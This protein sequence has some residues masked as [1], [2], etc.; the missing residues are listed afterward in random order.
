MALINQDKALAASQG[1]QA[2]HD[3]ELVK[4]PQWGRDIAQVIT[5]DKHAEVL[6]WAEML[7]G[8]SEWVGPQIW[9]NLSAQSI[10]LVPKKY[11]FP[12]EV[13]KDFIEDD[14]IGMF[15]PQFLNMG[16]MASNLPNK[17]V[18]E[19]L[20]AGYSTEC[21]DGGFFFAANH[22]DA[23]GH[24]QS[25]TGT[26]ALTSDSLDD[27]IDT[28]SAIVAAEIRFGLARRRLPER[29]AELVCDLLEVLP[30]EAFDEQVAKTYGRLRAELQ[31]LGI[32]LAAMDLLIAAH[33][34]ALERM[35]VSS[36]QVFASVPDLHC[37]SAG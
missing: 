28:M 12:V 35:L 14:S 23:N 36:D 3:A 22:P 15:A 7:G 11:S 6:T 30:V 5:S 33:A 18:S 17:L 37:C 10:T 8:F 4:H 32:T 20:V 27:A 19:L 26:A 34:L 13:G 1:F 9:Q 31:R 21:Y 25:N 16:I 29:H 2:L 24:S